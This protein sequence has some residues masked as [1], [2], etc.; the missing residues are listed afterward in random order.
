MHD[1]AD[2]VRYPTPAGHCID[3]VPGGD[4][5]KKGS[6]KPEEC[7][8]RYPEAL[9][10][11][12]RVARE[13]GYAIAVHGSRVRDLDLIA[14]PWVED[15]KPAIELVTALELAVAGYVANR[16]KDGIE[17]W[18]RKKP[19]GRRAWTIHLGG[20]PY[21]DLSVMPLGRDAG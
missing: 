18:P 2:P 14:V 3:E 17:E 15:A 12:T 5:T 19:H 21:I 6:I 16:T 10:I 7:A 8:K 20:G 1:G 4:L 13:M 9:L 11:A